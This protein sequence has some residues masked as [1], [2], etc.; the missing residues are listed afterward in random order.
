MECRKGYSAEATTLTRLWLDNSEQEYR[1]TQAVIE[2]A[3]I[4][5]ETREERIAMLA[6]RLHQYVVLHAPQEPEWV[7]RDFAR[8]RH[9]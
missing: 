6:G 9:P 2:E 7:Y 8:L 3:V 5:R 1:F 4:N